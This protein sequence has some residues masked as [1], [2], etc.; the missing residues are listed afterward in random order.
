MVTGHCWGKRGNPLG[1]VLDIRVGVFQK[2]K[3]Q[4]N[5]NGYV[6]DSYVANFV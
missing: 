2:A 1:T 6:E 4:K 3:E 5:A